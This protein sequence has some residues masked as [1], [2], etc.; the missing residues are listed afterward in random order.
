MNPFTPPG[1][2]PQYGNWR[3]AGLRS[4]AIL[5]AM[6]SSTFSCGCSGFLMVPAP[7]ARACPG[8]YGPPSAGVSASP[9]ITSVRMVAGTSTRLKKSLK[10]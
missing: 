5:P 4:K 2:D 9:S 6:L 1:K 8:P 10:N 7:A 3:N